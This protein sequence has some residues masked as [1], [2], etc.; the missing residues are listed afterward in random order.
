MATNSFTLENTRQASLDTSGFPAEAQFIIRLLQ[1]LEHGSL[2]MLFPDGQTAGFGNGTPAVSLNLRNWQV[3]NAILK[4][5]DI[6]F[7]ET[8]IDGHWTTNNL[9]ALI[10][11]ISYNRRHLE[12]IIYGTWW[13]NLLYRARHLLNRNSRTGSKKNIHA[14]YDIGND[15]YRL[16]LDPT[17]TYSSALFS[18]GHVVSLQDGQVNKYRR[19]LDELQ[20]GFGSRILEIGCGWGGF[21]EIAAGETGAHVTGL[22]L[23]GEQLEFAQQ[24]LNR[25]GLQQHSQL[26]LQDYRDSK[27]EYDAIASIE[28]FEAVGEK[29]WPSYFDCI[30]RNLKQ[31]G[32]ACI[33]TIVI[34]DAL[35]DRYRKGTDFIQQYIFPGG[36]LPSIEVFT[37][38]AENHGLKVVETFSFGMD[39]ARTLLEWRTAFA[40]KLQEIKAQGFDEKFL[41]TWEFY[42]AYCEAGFR[43]GS[44]NVT[45]FTLVK[46]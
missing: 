11:L 23:S 38:Y 28:M 9:P 26:K 33:Q 14:H 27:G 41:R 25:A 20:V 6:G 40:E 4:S 1:K 17:M 15:F 3:C 7:A 21:A 36:M 39:Y 13:G 31:H 18:S 32:R 43:A 19:I 30:H 2:Q 45:Q 35:F 22:T 42:L 8:Y 37:Q 46:P 12:E 16:W 29:Y 34:D 44:I 5:G 10:E 24:R